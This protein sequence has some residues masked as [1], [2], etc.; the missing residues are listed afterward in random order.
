M[1]HGNS[2]HEKSN[3]N[4]NRI[5][6]D[7]AGMINPLIFPCYSPQMVRIMEVLSATAA[8]ESPPFPRVTVSLALVAPIHRKARI[9]TRGLPR[10]VKPGSMALQVEE[11]V[12]R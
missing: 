5:A 11:D 8:S 9:L 2:E 6:D 12:K 10:E 4:A 1:P 7:P 3:D